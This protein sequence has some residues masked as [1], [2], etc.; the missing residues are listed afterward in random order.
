MHFSMWLG[1]IPGCEETDYVLM[2]FFL[3]NYEY[4]VWDKKMYPWATQ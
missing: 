3:L 1:R 4:K 2:L